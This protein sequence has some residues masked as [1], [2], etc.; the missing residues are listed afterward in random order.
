MRAVDIAEPLGILLFR[1]HLLR[2]L[3]SCCLV[4]L[5]SGEEYGPELG[6]MPKGMMPLRSAKKYCKD[7]SKKLA[8]GSKKALKYLSEHTS[9]AWI[10]GLKV[11]LDEIPSGLTVY[12]PKKDTCCQA[13]RGKRK[14]D[15]KYCSKCAGVLCSSRRR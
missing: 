13:K 8:M 10:R 6:P 9:R 15:K 4:L 14:C 12:Y 2:H 5:A 7:E 11:S 1:M 3:W